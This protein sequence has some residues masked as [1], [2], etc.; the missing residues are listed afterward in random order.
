MDKSIAS[1]FQY[2]LNHFRE[3]GE[4]IDSSSEV[5]NCLCRTLPSKIESIVSSSD[6][7]VIKAS[8]GMTN[9]ADCPWL[10][11]MNKSITRTTQKGLY[12][13]Y[14][15]KKDMSGLYITLNQGIKNFAT[16]YGKKKYENA[17]IVADYFCTQ[18]GNVSFSSEIIDLGA[19][20]STR[21]YGYGKATV[22]QKYYQSGKLDNNA[23][24]G[25]LRE[26]MSIYDDISKHMETSSYDTV[27]KSV[28]SES[29]NHLIK[30][31][32]AI[33]LIKNAVDPDDDMPFG[34]YR[35]L[36][37]VTP[38]VDKS[39]RYRRITNPP[40]TKI[41]YI[42]K[43]S[44]DK[45]IG[46]LGEQL[47]MSYEIERLNK[48]GLERYADKVYWASLESDAFG[49]DIISYDIDEKGKVKEIKIE[50]KTTS[51]KVDT[52]FYVTRNEL[53]KSKELGNN[54]CV[55]RIY[56]VNGEE[57][58]FYK[59]FGP[60]ENNFDLDPITYLASYKYPVMNN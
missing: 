3:M 33:E 31:D 39:N 51:S 43:A 56:D 11:I 1:D 4:R 2:V 44:K 8:A 48:L 42:K 10:A 45:R 23:M 16:L 55:Y 18:I 13:C 7:Y 27:I 12:V 59:A 17:R 50:V 58:K 53:E 21:G 22:I 49:Y 60:I 46:N 5:Y 47:V 57:P 54:Y 24:L 32:E 25:D 41:D 19:E 6:N 38:K 28:L 26:I 29:D 34:F 40:I 20:K 37:E 30:A 52:D 9:T 14:L 35:E 36:K 15:F